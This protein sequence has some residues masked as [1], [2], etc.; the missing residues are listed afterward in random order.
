MTDFLDE[1]RSEIAA[2]IK[3]LRPHVAEY[4]RL[5]AAVAA[6]D[7]LPPTAPAARRPAQRATTRRV[8]AAPSKT[9]RP[10]GRP[11]GSGTRGKEA[12]GLVRANPGIT[13]ADLAKE[14]GIKQNYLYRVL[15]ALVEENLVVK[16]GRGWHARA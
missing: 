5:E 4:E 16:D 7:G 10:R 8:A 14:M 9:G 6:L 1:K 13:I 11:K 15:P 2:R 12:L 3:E